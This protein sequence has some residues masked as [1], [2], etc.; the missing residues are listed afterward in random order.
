MPWARK[1]VPVE[2]Q[3]RSVRCTRHRG[4]KVDLVEVRR[5]YWREESQPRGTHIAAAAPAS[6]QAGRSAWHCVH[7]AGRV[8]AKW[9]YQHE[10]K[11]PRRHSHGND[12]DCIMPSWEGASPQKSSRGNVV[13]AELNQTEAEPSRH[14]G[15]GESVELMGA[16][17]RGDAIEAKQ[18]SRK[19]KSSR[20]N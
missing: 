12:G 4:C 13:E 1:S 14:V 11:L 7:R 3:D 6:G 19:A 9:P 2:R 8:E 17:S 10:R 16:L 5:P 15:R 20:P 18:S